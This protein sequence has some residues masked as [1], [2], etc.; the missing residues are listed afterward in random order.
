MNKRLERLMKVTPFLSVL[1]ILFGLI[2]GILSLIEHNLKLF[3]SS[4]FLIAQSIMLLSMRITY[5]K[6]WKR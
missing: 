6:M 3:T 4:L 2:M 5:R 1:F